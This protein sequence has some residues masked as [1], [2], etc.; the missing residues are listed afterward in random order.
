MTGDTEEL[1]PL[2]N[3]PLGDTIYIILPKQDRRGHQT[4]YKDEGSII[5]DEITQKVKSEFLDENGEYRKNA[6]L[7]L[8][9][10]IIVFPLM[11]DPAKESEQEAEDIL[12]RYTVQNKL[13]ELLKQP[14]RLNKK[15]VQAL[16]KDIARLLELF[17]SLTEDN[18]ET[19]TNTK[20]LVL[21]K[22]RT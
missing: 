19:N 8:K 21:V 18:T 5:V 20:S 15:E 9:V 4:I 16:I 10:R 1:H 6:R 7:H 11:A 12:K 14:D 2:H 13:S 22:G 3:Y 17:A